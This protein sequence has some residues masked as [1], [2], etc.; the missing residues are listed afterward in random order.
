MCD[1]FS[2]VK[3]LSLSILA[4]LSIPLSYAQTGNTVISNHF[5]EVELLNETNWYAEDELEEPGSAAYKY[6]ETKRIVQES[7]D[8]WAGLLANYYTTFDTNNKI[9]ITL[10]IFVFDNFTV[11]QADPN[12]VKLYGNKTVESNGLTYNTATSSTAKLFNLGYDATG[13]ADIAITMNDEYGYYFGTDPAPTG[14]VGYD[15]HTVFMHELTH[16]MG[17]TCYKYQVSG[18]AVN[19][20]YWN[21]TPY[22]TLIM[23]NTGGNAPTIGA[24]IELGDTGYNIYNPPGGNPGSSFSHYEKES[25]P[26]SL[27]RPSFDNGD[28]IRQLG[29]GDIAVFEAMGFELV[30]EPSTALLV[31]VLTPSF[32]LRRRRSA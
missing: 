25:Y 8:Y 13:D 29:A 9:T 19:T 21:T 6:G 32:L 17:F 27:M 11:G 22:D 16:G 7:I 26:D 24:T 23:E 5:F 31:L 4:L 1:I 2:I 12:F 3:H 20:F 30:P 28:V 18:G 10:D 14:L 15:F